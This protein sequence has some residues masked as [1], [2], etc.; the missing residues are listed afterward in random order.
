MFVQLGVEWTHLIANTPQSESMDEELNSPPHSGG[1][2][3]SHLQRI[4][5]IQNA[6]QP[7]TW[8]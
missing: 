5:T 2:D 6:H 7:P 1:Q 4:C 8:L 3:L